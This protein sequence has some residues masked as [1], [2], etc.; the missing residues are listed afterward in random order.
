M[1]L[2]RRRKQD[3]N[4]KKRTKPLKMKGL[5]TLKELLKIISKENQ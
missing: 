3:V 1:S 5:K 4:R 2:K